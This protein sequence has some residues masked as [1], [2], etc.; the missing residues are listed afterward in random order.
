[1]S[2]TIASCVEKHIL[3]KDSGAGHQRLTNIILA[4]WEAETG[5][6]KAQVR[7]GRDPTS[8]IIRFSKNGEQDNEQVLSGW[9]GT[10]RRWKGRKR[11]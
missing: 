10:N 11:V 9:V 5:S 1:M 2:E 8:K 6:I 7:T 3:Q 4:T